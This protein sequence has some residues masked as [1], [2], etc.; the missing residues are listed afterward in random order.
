MKRF[1]R[2][3]VVLAV[4]TTLVACDDSATGPAD[5]L[6]AEDAAFVMVEADA[7]AGALVFD[8]LGV[9]PV[10]RAARGYEGEFDR[11]RDCPAGGTFS[12]QGS[13]SRTEHGDGS[14]EWTLEATGEWDDCTHTRARGD[15]SVTTVIDGGFELEAHRRHNGHV[16]I[17]NQTT[18]KSGSFTWTRTSG[19]R[20]QQGEC[21]FDVT[22]VRNPDSRR[23]TIT[24]EVCGREI[25]R[26]LEWRNGM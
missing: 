13:S 11:S 5:D 19:E 18:T 2:S 10:L 12:I 1:T 22:S 16:P 8:L 24:G 7:M 21:S 6:D 17:G 3:V 26:T 15:R 23:V 14:V 25:D 9:G 4:L 20:S